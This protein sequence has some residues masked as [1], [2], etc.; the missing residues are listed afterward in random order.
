MHTAL[1]LVAKY[2]S[3]GHFKIR[4]CIENKAY[5]IELPLSLVYA[6]HGNRSSVS[7]FTL[8]NVS[9]PPTIDWRLATT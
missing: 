8:P 6:F 4:E 5:F 3:R 9:K 7:K 2:I 1:E